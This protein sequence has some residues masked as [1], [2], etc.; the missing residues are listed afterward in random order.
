[1]WRERRP[2][3]APGGML[4]ERLQERAT[5]FSIH[6]MNRISVTM[7]ARTLFWCGDV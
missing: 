4:A 1:L 2:V 5:Q 6:A 7:L 3:D